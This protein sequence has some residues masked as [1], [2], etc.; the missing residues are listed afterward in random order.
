MNPQGD[1]E[2]K[3][4]EF[5]EKHPDTFET[6]ITKPGAVL[7]RG[8]PIPQMLYGAARAIKVDTLAAAMIDLA[9]SGG[10]GKQAL[11]NADL[12]EKGRAAL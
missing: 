9:I 5:E 2:N 10:K 6:F 11:E 7:G 4:I 3:L 1:V 12:E 8:N